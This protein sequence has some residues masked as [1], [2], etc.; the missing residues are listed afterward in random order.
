MDYPTIAI[1]VAAGGAVA[2]QLVRRG[3]GRRRCRLRKRQSLLPPGRRYLYSRLTEAAGEDVTIQVAVPLGAVVT[4]AGRSPVGSPPGGASAS[5]PAWWERMAQTPLDFV[6][7]DA[8]TLAP[9]L[10]VLLDDPALSADRSQREQRRLIRRLGQ[11][12]LP[13][14]VLTGEREYEVEELE[15]VIDPRRAA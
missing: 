4:P 3:S 15:G 2:W 1:L 12:G 7:C 9:Q 8:R 5:V 13:C 11:A 14:L 10:V 6:L